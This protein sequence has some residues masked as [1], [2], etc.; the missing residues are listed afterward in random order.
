MDIRLLVSL[1]SAT[2]RFQPPDGVLF[3]I[4]PK[5]AI[6]PKGVYPFHKAHG[7]NDLTQMFGLLYLAAHLAVISV[8]YR[9]QIR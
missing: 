6:N 1:D 7:S 2:P 4:Q 9:V 5:L 3:P 8:T